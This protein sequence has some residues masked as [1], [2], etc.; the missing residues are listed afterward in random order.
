[1]SWAEGPGAVIR[2]RMVTA[3]VRRRGPARRASAQAA[4]GPAADVGGV[5][6]PV[7][8]GEL[9]P[10]DRGLDV[11]AERLGQDGGRDFGGQGEQGGA[12][13][14]AGA[15]PEGVEPL[16]EC[17]LGQRSSGPASGEEPGGRDAKQAASRWPAA[18]REP[19]HEGVQR[20]GQDDRAA[21]QAQESAA[22]LVQDVL[23]GQG[24]DDTELLGVE[25]DEEPGNPVGGRVGAVVEE[26]SRVCPSAVLV[27]RPGRSGP[28]RGRGCE[29]GG[30]AAG[31]CPADEVRRP[32]KV[33]GGPGQPLV[34]FGLGAGSQ[35][36]PACGEPVQERRG[37]GNLVVHV[38]GLLA[39][40][41]GRRGGRAGGEGG[42][43][44]HTREEHAGGRDRRARRRPG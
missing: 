39:G 41:A 29:A 44:G 14:L 25:Q 28:A 24:R 32:D 9:L 13:A 8:G 31:D 26:P 43:R 2:A 34:K 16:G 35:G 12:A 36:Q 22:V 10:L 4:N 20:G 11:D 3:P 5:G 15:D 27:E 30:V 6:G 17:V 37:G 7:P 38:L 23:G 21:A 1:M 18:V 40:G 42:A 33:G 19:G